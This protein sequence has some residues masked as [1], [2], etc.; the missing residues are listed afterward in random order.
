MTDVTIQAIPTEYRGHT[1]RSRTEA[2]WAVFFDALGLMWVYEPEGFKLP[3]GVWY[4]PDFWLP[5]MRMWVEVK[6]LDGPTEEERAKGVEL[7][8]GTGYAVLFLDG[9]PR[10]DT[11]VVLSHESLNNDA[12]VFAHWY[13]FSKRYTI[14]RKDGRPRLY[15]CADEDD[16]GDDPWVDEAG[17]AARAL[18]LTDPSAALP[19]GWEGIEVVE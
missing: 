15:W 9:P 6:P 17:Q 3:S 5:E 7:C 4:L 18:D 13:C 19:L 16:Y 14:D 10:H 2:R 8:E 11:F 12:E 1:F